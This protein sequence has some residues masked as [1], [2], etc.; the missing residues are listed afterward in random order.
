[1]KVNGVDQVPLVAESAFCIPHPL[2]FFWLNFV[3][4]QNKDLAGAA[5]GNSPFTP[6]HRLDR[7][8]KFES[9]RISDVGFY[10]PDLF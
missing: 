4:P 10:D 9:R 3:T 8:S 6:H 7:A 2:D 1:V 5:S